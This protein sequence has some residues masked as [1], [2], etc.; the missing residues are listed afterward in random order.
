MRIRFPCR[1]ARILSKATPHRPIAPL[2]LMSA[3][4]SHSASVIR[5]IGAYFQMPWLT[6]RISRPPNWSQ[7][8]A[9]KSR[10]WSQTDNSAAIATAVPFAFWIDATTSR[11]AG[12]SRRYPIA[13]FAPAWAS[14]IAVARPIPREPPET[15]ATWPAN[16][17]EIMFRSLFCSWNGL[18]I[19]FDRASFR[20]P[21]TMGALQP[22]F[23]FQKQL[24]KA[25]GRRAPPSSLRSDLKLRPQ[26]SGQQRSFFVQSGALEV[27]DRRANLVNAPRSFVGSSLQSI[28]QNRSHLS[29]RK[30]GRIVGKFRQRLIACEEGLPIWRNP[31]RVDL[32]T[33]ARQKTEKGRLVLR[34]HQKPDAFRHRIRAI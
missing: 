17:T 27:D 1:W 3:V 7:Q 16:D 32:Q 9:T 2:R 5:S 24:A 13:T 4:S 34:G 21:A 22:T 25:F 8:F 12:S 23:D 6:T 31:H 11:A 18:P 20:L 15:R 28:D 33:V 29:R 14:R 30:V 10:A 19:R 26:F